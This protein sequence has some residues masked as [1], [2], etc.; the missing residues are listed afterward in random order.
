M[1]TSPEAALEA[2]ERPLRAYRTALDDGVSFADST[3]HPPLPSCPWTW[4]HLARYL[5][6]HRMEQAADD[7]WTVNKMQNNGIEVHLGPWTF[8]PLKAAAAGPPSTGTNIRRKQFYSQYYIPSMF[9]IEEDH[10]NLLL[11]WTVGRSRLPFL[12]L[13]K[14]TSSWGYGK[15]PQLA[16]RIPVE[17]PD[18]GPRAAFSPPDADDD[19]SVLPDIDD[20][21]FEEGE[22]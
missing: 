8:R 22:G 14:P 5:S 21:E 9:D 11:D 13:S 18:D 16:W 4:A 1:D 6:A 12:W 7:S 19:I 15:K 2:L 3:L 17:F 20:L 10:V